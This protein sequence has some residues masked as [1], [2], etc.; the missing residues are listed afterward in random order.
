MKQDWKKFMCVTHFD[1][2]IAAAEKI[3]TDFGPERFA[4]MVKDSGADAA[5]IF[6]KCHCGH[7]Y[8]PT[9]VGHRHPNL[10]CDMFGASLEALHRENLGAMAYFSGAYDG[11]CFREHPEWAFTYPDG[12]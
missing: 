3:S 10:T 11:H 4:R 5:Y 7:F 9:D 1:M 6:A 2:H 12:T 8:Y